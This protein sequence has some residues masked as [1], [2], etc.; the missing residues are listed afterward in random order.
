M[1][2]K[3]KVYRNYSY[4]DKSGDIIPINGVAL[5]VDHGTLIFR[6]RTEAIVL[7]VAPTGWSDLWTEDDND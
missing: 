1:T 7:A 3:N 2:I 6:D 4:H 5:A